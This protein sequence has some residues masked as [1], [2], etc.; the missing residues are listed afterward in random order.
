MTG[1]DTKTSINSVRHL[2]HTTSTLVLATQSYLQLALHSITHGFDK[3]TALFSIAS[4]AFHNVSIGKQTPC[5]QQWLVVYEFS[6]G[7]AIII[8]NAFLFP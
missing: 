4:A 8:V 3:L 5:V 1:D 6:S 7:R 2:L